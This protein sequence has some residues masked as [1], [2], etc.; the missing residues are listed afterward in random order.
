MIKNKSKS[1]SS[2]FEGEGERFAERLR[3]AIWLLGRPP[4]KSPTQSE[5]AQSVQNEIGKSVSQ[6]TVA[7]W[8]AGAFPRSIESMLALAEV[9]DVDPGW[10]YFGEASKA[11]APGQLEHAAAT[12]A[13]PPNVQIPPV[14]SFTRLDTT[15]GLAKAKAEIK[16][17]EKAFAS[18]KSKPTHKKKSG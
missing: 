8:L 9:L 2:R 11:P 1:R 6:A 7:G 16:A 15:E 10:L 5:L 18:L 14:E 17:A 12:L 4:G 13:L 3:H